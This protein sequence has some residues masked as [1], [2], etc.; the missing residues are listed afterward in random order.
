ME[1]QTYMLLYVDSHYAS[2]YAMSVFV[3]LH[4]KAASFQ[5][6]TVD[7]VAGQNKD[8]AY[9]EASLTQ[10]VPTL[11]DGEF[12]LSESSAIVEYLDEILPAAAL[13]PSEPKARARARQV[14]AWLRS[15]L[16]PI[17]AE[18][19]TEVVFYGQH[20]K[21]LSPEAEVAADKLFAAASSLL[22]GHHR[23]LFDNWCIADLDLALMLNRLV[24]HG[25]PVPKN[26]EIYAQRQWERP[27]V[28]L[29][30]ELE[31]PPL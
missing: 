14:Q 10:R 13:Y 29:W 17:R 12:A 20:Y 22:A 4:E 19:P 25:D 28:Q 30:V 1:Y 8:G 21:P 24:M 9:A 27:S 18:R 2:P 26:L 31:R 11:V 6:E 16:D 23:N 3:A 5:M 7:L 15:D